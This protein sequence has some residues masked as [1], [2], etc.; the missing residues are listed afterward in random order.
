MWK[1]GINLY[2]VT[3]TVLVLLPLKDLEFATVCAQ[4]SILQFQKCEEMIGTL[5]VIIVRCL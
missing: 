2:S 3:V 4:S 5:F 1:K